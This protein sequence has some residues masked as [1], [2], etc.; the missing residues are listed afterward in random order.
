ML[1]MVTADHPQIWSGQADLA[2]PLPPAP[3]AV[4]SSELMP[5]VY[6]ELRRLAASFLRGERVDHTLQRTALVHEA[7]LR[8][9]R[10]PDVDWNDRSHF[11]GVCAR[12]MRQTLASY[13]IARK[14]EKRGGVDPLSVAMEFYDRHDVDVGA[15]DEALHGLE[16]LDPRQAKIVEMRFFGGFTAEEIAEALSISPA[17]VKREWTLAK[18]WLRHELSQ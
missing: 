6:D 4:P 14:R 5:L 18:V 11:L 16:E 7:F 2:P 13:A 15:I 1:P 9:A 10:H 17:T 8:L 3:L 12:V